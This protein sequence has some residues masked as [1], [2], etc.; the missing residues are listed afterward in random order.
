VVVARELTKLF[1]ECRN[2]PAAELAAHYGACPAKGE[3]ALLVAPPREPQVQDF[4]LDALLRAE[5][6][7]SKPSQAAAAVAKATGADRKQLY[8]R[9]LELK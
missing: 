3:I 4:D 2:G 7:N 5:L 9:A 1:E 8:A 6:V